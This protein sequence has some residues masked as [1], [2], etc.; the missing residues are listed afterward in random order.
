LLNTCSNPF[1]VVGSSCSK[2]ISPALF[3]IQNGCC[4]LLDPNRSVNWLSLKI[5][6]AFTPQCY[7]SSLPVSF[8]R[9]ERVVHWER[10]ASRW[11]P[12]FSSHLVNALTGEVEFLL[13][14][15]FD[16]VC[17]TSTPAR[18]ASTIHLSVRS[19]PKVDPPRPTASLLVQEAF[20]SR[21]YPA[22]GSRHRLIRRMRARAAQPRTLKSL[23]RS[24]IVEPV[25]AGL[26]AVDDRVARGRV[27]L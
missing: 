5:W 20:P 24:V 27:M 14:Q 18:S 17:S 15:M 12:A 22:R 2:T 1:G 8:L 21:G 4:D 11:R 13:R 7:S 16:R 26:E 9:L 19:T 6:I 23:S 25:F 3:K 10:I